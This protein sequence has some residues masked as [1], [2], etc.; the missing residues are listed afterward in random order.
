[1][2]RMVVLGSGLDLSILRVF[3]ICNNSVALC[4]TSQSKQA[5][6]RK[7]PAKPQCQSLPLLP[8]KAAEREREKWEPFHLLFCFGTPAPGRGGTVPLPVQLRSQYME[9]GKLRLLYG[10]FE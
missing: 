4:R 1:M 5:P 8:T 7:Q 9:M 10:N 2:V 6:S 3:P